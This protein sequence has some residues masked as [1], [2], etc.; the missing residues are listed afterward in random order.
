MY[1]HLIIVGAG[2]H[3]QAVADL[4]LSTGN[5]EKVSFV[6]DCYPGKKIALGLPICGKAESLLNNTLK[7]DSCFVAIGNNI[8]REKIINQILEL[9]LPLVN[10][11]HPKAW[12]S[13]FAELAGGVAV[14]AGAVVG[15]N[16]KLALGSLI[17]ANATI[18][19][20]CVLH[21]Y[22]HIGVGVQ[23]AG[24]V[25]IG[26]SAWLQAGTCAGYFVNVKPSVIHPPGSVLISKST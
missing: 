2:G 3:G 10:L 7:F 20:D 25:H 22:A 24:G 6:D 26:P 18:D 12:V 5:F 15:T 11:V 13:C 8:V 16:T 9:E 19:H 1:N 17:N 4:A 21:E 23:L 14:M